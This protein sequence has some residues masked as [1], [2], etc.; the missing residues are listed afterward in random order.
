MVNC[1]PQQSLLFS[2]TKNLPA[3]SKKDAQNADVPSKT[4]SNAKKN[5]PDVD[6]RF[7]KNKKTANWRFFCEFACPPSGPAFSPP[8]IPAKAGIGAL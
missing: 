3:D 1:L 4:E 2:V 8:V 5:Q 6:L 7:G